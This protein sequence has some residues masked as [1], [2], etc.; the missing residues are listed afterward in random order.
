M[1]CSAQ[2]LSL[3]TS[4]ASTH[5]AQFAPKRSSL[6]KRRQVCEHDTHFHTDG[7]DFYDAPDSAPPDDCGIDVSVDVIQANMVQ[8]RD[9][10]VAARSRMSFDKWKQLNQK[11]KDIWDQLTDEAKE[12]ILK[13]SQRKP[14]NNNRP[15]RP[16]KF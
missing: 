14:G 2:H 11:S 10:M 7:E 13:P 5:G 6:T 16:E 1:P 3:L 15:G 12:I 9:A 8:Q 4:A